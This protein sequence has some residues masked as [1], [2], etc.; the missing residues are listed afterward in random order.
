V[1]VVKMG[2]EEE[3]VRKKEGVT[4]FGRVRRVRTVAV[5][6]H[7]SIS[8]FIAGSD[9]ERPTVLRSPRWPSSLSPLSLR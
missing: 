6:Q 9:L 2:E 3:K 1:G 4:G 8:P 7:F 5:A